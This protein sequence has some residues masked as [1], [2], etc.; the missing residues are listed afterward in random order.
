MAVSKIT[1]ST[2]PSMLINVL[3]SFSKAN[4]SCDILAPSLVGITPL[5]STL[6]LAIKLENN[7]CKVLACSMV[8][9]SGSSLD[10]VL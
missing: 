9:P 1:L 2:S 10:K 4:R 7:S 8:T 3:K 6:K 5:P